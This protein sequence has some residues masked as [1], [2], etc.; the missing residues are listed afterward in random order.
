[1]NPNLKNT[2]VFLTLVLISVFVFAW[3]QESKTS[4]V[5]T[6]DTN[7]TLRVLSY[8]SFNSL[9]GPGPL[10]VKK[11]SEQCNCKVKMITVD[12]A[13]L[14]LQKLILD[15]SS[16]D[17][18][19]GFDQFTQMMAKHRLS[20]RRLKPPAH[21]LAAEVRD[22]ANAEF[23]PYDWAPMTFIY[24]KSDQS[25]LKYFKDLFS[26][27]YAKSISLQDPRMSSAGLQFLYWLYVRYGE[28]LMF[29]K[30]NELR[31]NI[32]SISPSWSLAY[33][34]FQKQ[35]TKI[36]FSYQTS[37]LYHQLEEASKDYAYLADRKGHP[38]QVE[39]MAIPSKCRQCDLANDFVDFMLS[40]E[41][42]EIIMTKNYMFPAV[43]FKNLDSKHKYV[44]NFIRM[45]PLNLV[46][47]DK[48]EEFFKVKDQLLKKW[49]QILF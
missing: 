45:K 16:A 3:L 22:Y 14:I 24:R 7:K 36:T 40:P 17:L 44:K 12:E 5:E 23:L 9:F 19:I 33:G 34:L 28:E 31:P 2:I 27:D 38:A 37:V 13:G 1:M 25:E 11:F 29:D 49:Q 6:P 41:A 43:N 46:T 10:L 15:P 20:W 39:F 42:Q 32:H 4:F 21:K 48:R 47:E 35:Q 8:S 30:L 26:T 18:V